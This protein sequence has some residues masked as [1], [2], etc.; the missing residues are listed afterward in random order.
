MMIND[1]RC[2]L[3]IITTII[4]IIIGARDCTA[5]SWTSNRL[6]LAAY[7]TITAKVSVRLILPRAST[8]SQLPWKSNILWSKVLLRQQ[9]ANCNWAK[10]TY[11]GPPPK[12][13]RDRDRPFVN[14]ATVLRN[15]ETGCWDKYL[16]TMIHNNCIHSWCSATNWIFHIG[17]IIVTFLSPGGLRPTQGVS[18]LQ[19]W[20]TKFQ[21]IEVAKTHLAGVA[22]L[23]DGGT[24]LVA[25]TTMVTRAPANKIVTRAPGREYGQKIVTG[26]DLQNSHLF[27][28]F[29]NQPGGQDTSPCVVSDS[30]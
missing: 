24:L 19:Q 14:T 25:P 28:N 27:R 30:P 17:N 7:L 1:I 5:E 8:Y 12:Q 15:T 3:F 26:A 29:K 9:I 2:S 21:K 20:N 22:T 23:P 18:N 6:S 11:N 13:N 4:V 16:E 10:V